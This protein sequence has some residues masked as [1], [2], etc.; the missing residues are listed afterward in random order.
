M[1]NP[2]FRF[3]EF[4]IYQDQC[5]MKVS[6]DA[7]IFGAWLAEKIPSPASVLDIGSGTGLLMLMLVQKNRVSI[8]GIEIDLPS[9][10]QLKTNISATKWKDHLRVFPGDVRSFSFPRKYDYI[11]SNPPFFEGDLLSSMDTRNVARHSKALTL[12][13]L[14]EVIDRNLEPQGH[15]GILLPIHRREEW[16]EMAEAR[17]FHLEEELSIR[18]TRDHSYF[19]VILQCARHPSKFISRSELTIQCET[20]NYSDEFIELLKDYYLNL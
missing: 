17:G 18:Q 8:D 7:C 2:Y 9:F 14:M 16:M 1:P 12:K 20:S 3:K 4:T 13:E 5:A 19:R 6:T 10:K 11:L 15:F